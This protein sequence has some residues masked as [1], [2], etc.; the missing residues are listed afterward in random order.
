MLLLGR[1]ASELPFFM[2]TARPDRQVRRV[3]P[4]AIS[5][6]D[7]FVNLARR[8]AAEEPNA[9]FADQFENPANFN[10]HMDTGVTPG[11]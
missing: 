11:A 7:H 6:P 10:A 1:K 2:L 8:R 3:R 5:H 4:V 9:V